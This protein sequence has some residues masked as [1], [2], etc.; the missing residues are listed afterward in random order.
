MDVDLT[1]RTM[2]AMVGDARLHWTHGIKKRKTDTMPDGSVRLREDRWSLT[3]RWLRNGECECG[4]IELCDVAQRRNGIEKEKRSL[5]QLAEES[6]G[7]TAS[8]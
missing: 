7:Q 8:D 2:M 6:A 4:N 5:K 1:P 3:Y